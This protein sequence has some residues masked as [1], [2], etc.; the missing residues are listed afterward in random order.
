VSKRRAR[1]FLEYE[2]D[3]SNDDDDE[4]TEL[5]LQQLYD[6]RTWDL[7]MRI[8]EAR[9]RKPVPRPSH[10]RHIPHAR[11]HDARESGDEYRYFYHGNDAGT[12]PTSSPDSDYGWY[13]EYRQQHRSSNASL[14]MRGLGPSDHQHHE[15]IF[16]D[17]EL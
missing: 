6:L 15:L 9:K 14:A 17:L 16:G 8:T 4:T 3:N 5:H 1:R 7:Y 13:D 11:R 12:E 2:W 10:Q